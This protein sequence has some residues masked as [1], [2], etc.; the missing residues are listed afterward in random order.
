MKLTRIIATAGITVALNG[1]VACE[2]SST[3]PAQ[4]SNA[5]ASSSA[6][7]T[8]SNTSST[9]PTADAANVP[10]GSGDARPQSTAGATPG[11]SVADAARAAGGAGIGAGASGD[12]SNLPDTQPTASFIT[13][14]GKVFSFPR[15]MLRLRTTDTGVTALL[16]SDDPPA[17]LRDNYTGN[18]YYLQMN[19]DIT[20]AK[21]IGAA[22][23]IFR[24][25]DGIFLNGHAIELQPID[26]QVKFD[27]AAPAVTISLSG[28]FLVLHSIHEDNM[29]PPVYA[30]VFAD[31][32][33]ATVVGK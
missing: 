24:S 28:K 21:D 7:G 11:G 20:D 27:G 15:A 18:S 8:A 9:Q 32:L 13:V 5:S 4:A 10:A 14:N 12:A 3:P 17:A 6:S 19:L 23:W 26:V 33:L 31:G 16:Y 22:H 29:G 2:R 30:S 1:L 25:P